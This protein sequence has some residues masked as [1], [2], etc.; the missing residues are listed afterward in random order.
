MTSSTYPITITVN[1]ATITAGTDIL[2]ADAAITSDMVSPGGGGVVRLYFSYGFVG[3]AT[4]TVFNNNV[5]KGQLNADNAA[6][7]FTQGFY[8]FDLDVEAGD[9]LNFQSSVDI[10]TVNFM[11]LHL[12]QFG[13]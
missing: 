7:V 10:T 11:R 1:A 4:I 12:V 3:P 13:A 8:R 6:E 9:N 2:T 5:S